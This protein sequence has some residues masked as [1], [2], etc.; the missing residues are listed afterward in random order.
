MYAMADLS[1][2]VVKQYFAPP[3]A[4][5]EDIII[6]LGLCKAQNL[7]P[8]LSDCYMI[9]FQGRAGRKYASVTAYQVLLDR[10]DPFIEGLEIDCEPDTDKPESCTVTVHRRGWKIPFKRK[11]LMKQVMRFKR[12]GKPMALWATNERAMLEKCAVTAA[13]RMGVSVCR[14]FYIEE[15]FY[16]GNQEAVESQVQLSQATVTSARPEPDIDYLRGQYFKYGKEIWADEDARHK[17]NTDRGFP[18]SVKDWSAADYDIAIEMLKNETPS[19]EPEPADY[20]D[21]KSKRLTLSPEEANALAGDPAGEDGAQGASAPDDGSDIPF[22]SAEAIQD[23]LNKKIAAAYHRV[24]EL[25]QDSPLKT[26][27]EP[28][29]TTWRNQIL[30]DE[31]GVATSDLSL[32]DLNILIGELEVRENT[33]ADEAAEA[34]KENGDLF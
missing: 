8:W 28:P 24:C 32:E 33:D 27:S 10:A 2:K 26:I 31:K 29:F 3:D 34:T 15:E 4:T 1:E 17:W 13:L 21:E 30:V 20:Y 16:A 5:R 25:V 11:T 22:E 23:D 14:R 19:I 18:E 9:P 6:F 12:D 7:N